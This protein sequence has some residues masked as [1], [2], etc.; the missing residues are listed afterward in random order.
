MVVAGLLLS[1][2]LLGAT[3]SS[4]QV[5]RTKEERGAVIRGLPW[6]NGG[7]FHLSDSRIT[8]TLDKRFLAV[9][10]PDAR[11]FD[12]AI[13]AARTSKNLEAVVVDPETD[14]FVLFHHV[15]EGYVHFDD[16]ND[17]DAER[18]MQGIKESTGEA[19]KERLANN[20]SPIE[21]VG[22][23][24]KPALDRTTQTVSWAIDGKSEDG[25]IVNAI[26]LTFGRF[27]YER[28]T[29][30]GSPEHDP[31]VFL[32]AMRE[33]TAFE[34][35]ARYTDFRKGDKVAEYGIAALVAGLVGAKAVAKI[36]LLVL[37]KKFGVV[38]LAALAGLGAFVRRIMKG[39]R[40]AQQ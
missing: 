16:W 30:I 9:T 8:L 36:G 4:A 15:A 40:S 32:G 31:A 20:S 34:V 14:D 7:V 1:V 27:G 22:W 38:V 28:L 6:Q 17:V 39:E 24:A 21:V 33:S 10:G 19:N 26:V 11:K 29:W 3:Y 5:P 13:Q 12:E 23:R 35:G 18:M 2:L 37:L 25:A